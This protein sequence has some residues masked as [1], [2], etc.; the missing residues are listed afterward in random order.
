MNSRRSIGRRRTC[1]AKSYWNIRAPE[2]I[3]DERSPPFGIYV[4]LNDEGL[5]EAL[6]GIRASI[7]LGR[8]FRREPFRYSHSSVK[9]VDQELAKRLILHASGT[10]QP[11]DLGLAGNAGLDH[12]EKHR[13]SIWT[14]L[15]LSN[16]TASHG[17]SG[18]RGTQD[19]VSES[20]LFTGSPNEPQWRKSWRKEN[21][22][23]RSGRFHGIL[24]QLDRAPIAHDG[25]RGTADTRMFRPPHYLVLHGRVGSAAVVMAFEAAMSHP[26][27]SYGTEGDPSMKSVL[28]RRSSWFSTAYIGSA[29]MS[30]PPSQGG[31]NGLKIKSQDMGHILRSSPRVRNL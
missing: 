29:Y 1:Q 15:V 16:H 28:F 12:L 25:L 4:K 31:W 19:S 23:R 30:L 8:S 17:L 26:C 18:I 7:L 22:F 20:S 5:R 24:H 6:S 2:G 27:F 9:V 14:N 10:L 13:W 11:P 21:A 3:H